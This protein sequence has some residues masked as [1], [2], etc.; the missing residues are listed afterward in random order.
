MMVTNSFSYS[1]FIDLLHQTWQ[2][3]S[4]KLAHM[5]HILLSVVSEWHRPNTTVWSEARLTVGVSIYPAEPWKSAKWEAVLFACFGPTELFLLWKLLSVWIQTAA[6][7]SRSVWF[8]CSGVWMWSRV[9]GNPLWIKKGCRPDVSQ[10]W[11]GQWVLWSCQCAA[12]MRYT[13][14]VKPWPL[15]GYCPAVMSRGLCI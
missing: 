9:V 15:I 1:V 7:K 10:G 4:M 5:F 13:L 6:A 8:C 14:K 12:D 3:C 2:T 11:R